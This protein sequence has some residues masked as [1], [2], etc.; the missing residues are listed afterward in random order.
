MVPI[1]APRHHAER[2]AGKGTPTSGQ[3]S[4]WGP[5]QPAA[6]GRQG[7]TPSWRVV[8]LSAGIPAFSIIRTAAWY[9]PLAAL[10]AAVPT[11]GRRSLAAGAIWTVGVPA[12][13]CIFTAAGRRSEFPCLRA[14]SWVAD[15]AETGAIREFGE[16]RLRGAVPTGVDVLLLATG[17]RTGGWR[18][19]EWRGG[20]RHASASCRGASRS[21]GPASGRRYWVRVSRVNEELAR[22]TGF[23]RSE[24]ATAVR[25]G[26]PRG[27]RAPPNPPPSR[28]SRTIR[29]RPR[30]RG[31]RGCRRDGDREPA[32]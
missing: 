13:S 30:T 26:F 17:S 12:R 25:A 20:G 2:R 23:R 31:T 5:A 9:T 15:S 6:G 21:S 19:G 29:R 3:F 10:C 24:P 14:A 28:G 16:T 32:P 8:R 7:R 1:S 22:D 4:R 27:L 18:C 11:R